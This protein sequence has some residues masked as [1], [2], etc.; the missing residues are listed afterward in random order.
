MVY[1]E[2]NFLTMRCFYRMKSLKK[3]DAMTTL[4]DY[5]T[6]LVRSKFIKAVKN[7][8]NEPRCYT[9]VRCGL[10]GVRK[11]SLLTLERAQG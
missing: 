6:P 5:P 4:F 2:Q 1:L 9:C 7:N 8:D 3:L 10:K 11:V